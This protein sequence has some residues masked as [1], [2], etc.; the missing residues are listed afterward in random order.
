[1]FIICVEEVSFP[2]GDLFHNPLL[3]NVC[4]DFSAFHGSLNLKAVQYAFTQYVLSFSYLRSMRRI[5]FLSR[6]GSRTWSYTAF[7]TYQGTL[8]SRPIS[9]Y[10]GYASPCAILCTY[11]NYIYYL[12]WNIYP[13]EW[14]RTYMS[15]GSILSSSRMSYFFRNG[16]A[17]D[18]W[19][20]DK[21][22]S[23]W[24]SRV[25]GSC[26]CLPHT[27]LST[28]SHISESLHRLLTALAL[29]SQPSMVRTSPL[30]VGVSP[31]KKQV[32]ARNW[33]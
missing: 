26:V 14:G 24:E 15:Q 33:K 23:S 30:G 27:V 25:I 28:L 2:V 5:N 7:S 16:H 31:Q 17:D 13:C 32:R 3:S 6:P 10:L 19:V 8:A 22:P 4:S 21:P 11:C 18:I 1:M 20:R 9:A 29:R 12:T